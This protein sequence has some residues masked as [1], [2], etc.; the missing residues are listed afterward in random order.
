MDDPTVLSMRDRHRRDHLDR[1][2]RPGDV[3]VGRVARPRTGSPGSPADARVRQAKKQDLVQRHPGSA[4]RDRPRT[5]FV[6]DAAWSPTPK[7]ST[8]F[9][10]RPTSASRSIGSWRSSVGLGVAGAIFGLVF[11][12]PIYAVPLA[13]LLWAPCRSSG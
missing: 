1:R 12:L 4:R 8:C 13:A 6:L 10:N 2:A 7:T 5:S 3:Q 11:R 9:T